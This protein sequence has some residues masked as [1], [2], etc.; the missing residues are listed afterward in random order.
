MKKLTKDKMKKIMAGGEICLACADG[1]HQVIRNG[2]C[3][4]E[5]D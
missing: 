1:Y 5:P 3:T 2:R 4:C